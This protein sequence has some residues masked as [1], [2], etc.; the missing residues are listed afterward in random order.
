MFVRTALICV[1]LTACAGAETSLEDAFCDLLA[2]TPGQAV[3]AAEDTTGAPE[4]AFE[5]TRVEVDLLEG[6]DGMW[7]GVVA[8][9][10]DEAGSR[11]AP[12]PSAL[13]ASTKMRNPE[14]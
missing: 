1:A 10:A 12:R 14:K 2:G 5:D 9:T 11:L 8:Y 3:T 13:A 4:V 7:S 6:E